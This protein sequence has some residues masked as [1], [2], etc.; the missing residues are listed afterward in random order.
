MSE[1]VLRNASNGNVLASRVSRATNFITRGVGLLPRAT[2][3]EDEGLWID[4]CSAVHTVGMRATIDLFF[5]D[6]DGRILKIV[7]RARP[8]RLVI[9]CARSVSVVELG[10][11]DRPRDVLVGD[12]LVLE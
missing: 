1:Q 10:H 11:G 6:R 8:N 5:L 4:G 2:V 3:G 12:R 7:N 9:S